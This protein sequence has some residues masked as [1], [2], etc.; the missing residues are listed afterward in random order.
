MFWIFTVSI[1]LFT[2]IN[3]TQLWTNFVLVL[4]KP[5]FSSEW[6]CVVVELGSWQ[7]T[8]SQYPNI[9]RSNSTIKKINVS[10][11]FYCRSRPATMKNMRKN[12]NNLE[13]SWNISSALTKLLYFDGWLSTFIFISFLNLRRALKNS[14]TFDI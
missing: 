12:H 2:S 10:V 8:F 3:L 4:V 14:K 1:N 9:W 7:N 6:R 5:I 13:I 11:G